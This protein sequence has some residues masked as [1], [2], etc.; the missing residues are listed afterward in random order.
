[1]RPH[2][3]LQPLFCWFSQNPLLEQ[4]KRI[5]VTQMS[6]IVPAS[7]SLYVV[8]CCYLPLSHIPHLS[9][10]E[11]FPE[12]KISNTEILSFMLQWPF[13]LITRGLTTFH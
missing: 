11:I 7:V 13:V 3:D 8:I 10:D 6:V 1:M 12:W 2:A 4:D 5:L 9:K